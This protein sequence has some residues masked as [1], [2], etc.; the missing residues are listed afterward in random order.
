MIA[1]PAEERL[2]NQVVKAGVAYF[3]LV[4]AAGFALGAV[5]VPLIAP[6]IGERAAELLETPF[7]LAVIVL[8]ARWIVRRFSLAP[9]PAV[10]LGTGLLALA[11]MLAAEFGFVLRLRGMTIVGYL[12]SRDPVSGTVYYASLGMLAVMPL[13]VRRSLGVPPPEANRTYPGGAQGPPS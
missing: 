7:M 5:R 11:L 12:A 1:R 3:A 13:I 10:R 8:S 9:A 6:R 2:L 4:F